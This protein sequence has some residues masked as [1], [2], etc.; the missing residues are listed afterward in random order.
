MTMRL[1]SVPE[2]K[3]IFGVMQVHS[4]LPIAFLRSN[5]RRF[6]MADILK[7]KK[8]KVSAKHKGKTMCANN[9]H[10]WKVETS[11]KFDVQRGKLVTL[12]R[13]ERCGEEKTRLL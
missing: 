6:G 1:M 8:R 4:Q 10:K 13:C 5:W 11:R 9:H 12:Y 3:Q 2:Q 7:F